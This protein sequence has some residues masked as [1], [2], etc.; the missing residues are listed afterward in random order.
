[1]NL[2]EMGREVDRQVRNRQLEHLLQ[3]TKQLTTVLCYGDLTWEVLVDEMIELSHWEQ[4]PD[5][6]KL[7]LRPE[8]YDLYER[9]V[10]PI[11]FKPMIRRKV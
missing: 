10:D 5:T 6:K 8:H 3:R 2:Q 4:H 9:I 1:M 7:M 11:S